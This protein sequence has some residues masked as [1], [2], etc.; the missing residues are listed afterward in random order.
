[1]GFTAFA[2]RG[3]AYHPEIEGLENT[4]AA[5]RH[6]YD[7]GYRNLETDVHVTADGHLVA[8]HDEVLDRVTDTSGAIADLT[9]EQLR[10]AR[11][12]DEQVPTLVELL[13]EFGDAD[14]N[15]DLKSGAAVQPMVDLINQRGLHDRFVIGTFSAGSTA[16]AASPTGGSAPRRTVSRC[17]RSGSCPPHWPAG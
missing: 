13:N 14:W 12:Q 1:M 6:A 9:L 2:H 4:M 17:S 8:F 5:F 10:Q 3:G 11:I 15:I 7:L 16:S